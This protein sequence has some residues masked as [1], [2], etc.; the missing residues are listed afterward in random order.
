MPVP[1]DPSFAREERRA[2]A[3]EA[4]AA[5]TPEQL[6]DLKARYGSINPDRPRPT[7]RSSRSSRSEQVLDSAAIASV[8]RAGL[9]A[10]PGTW[11]SYAELCSAS[12]LDRQ[13]ALV[14]ARH[15]VPE[16]TGEHWFR[17]RNGDGVYNMPT[18]EA[19]RGDVVRFGQAEA[20][21]RLE[22]IGVRV[23]DRRAD[24]RRKIVWTSTGWQLQH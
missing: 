8:A 14:V 2:R 15:L 3:R 5:A 17:I 6:Q 24:R 18:D 20:D 1:G 23:V 16:P 11:T 22:E 10:H 12:G 21:R 9:D 19:K 13:L 7:Q 4:A